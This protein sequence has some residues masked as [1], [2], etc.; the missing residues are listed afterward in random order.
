L[1]D[2]L[3]REGYEPH[4]INQA[5]AEYD[6]RRQQAEAAPA[7][8]AAPAAG[9][10]TFWSHAL[11]VILVLLAILINSGLAAYASMAALS[12]PMRHPSDTGPL[13][14]VATLFV[15]EAVG[16]LLMMLSGKLRKL[17]CGILCAVLLASAVGMLSFVG[18]C[19]VNM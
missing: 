1:R 19:M 12:V 18:Y 10:P 9:S 5:I 7:L 6:R 3:L 2:Q 16:A 13:H 4:L 11:L 14:L 17:G 8:P 15:A